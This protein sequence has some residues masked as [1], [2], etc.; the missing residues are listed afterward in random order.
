MNNTVHLNNLPWAATE[1]EIEQA[2]T[3]YGPVV[4]VSI[5]LDKTTDRPRG[6]GFVEFSSP[7][8]AAKAIADTGRVEL[9]G[10]TLKVSIA[11][12]RP[13]RPIR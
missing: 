13:A 8:A 9:G 7:E 5:V 1:Q 11:T 12:P 4:R 6:F 3:A 10:R 2:F